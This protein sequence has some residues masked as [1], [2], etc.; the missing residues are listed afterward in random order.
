MIASAAS[1]DVV[2]T[3]TFTSDHCTGGCLTG[4]TNGGTVTVTDNGA[5][6]LTFNI[7]L[8]NGNQ[9][10]NSGFEASF[11]FNLVGNPTIT[12]SGV[13]PSA[14]Y[15]VPG[16]TAL[17]PAGPDGDTQTAGALHMDG[18]GTFEYGLEGIGSGGSDPLGS[19]LVFTIT[20][21]GLDITDLQQNADLQFFAADIISGTT[22]LTGGIDVSTLGPP[23]PPPQPPPVP[24]PATVALFG[25]GLIAL[26]LTFGRRRRPFSRG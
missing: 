10:I 12:Y 23:L 16:G 25:T 21:A 2:V 14:D 15:T 11:G 17:P 5:G 20:G 3:G 24:E 9:F 6:S 1:A 7:Q 4:Q 18:T 26:A 22:A 13:T 8:A 19:S